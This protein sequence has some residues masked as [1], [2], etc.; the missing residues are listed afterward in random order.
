[1]PVLWPAMV[2]SLIACRYGT[3]L[4][5]T[6]PWTMP[7]LGTEPKAGENAKVSEVRFSSRTLSLPETG[8]GNGV[9]VTGLSGRKIVL[10]PLPA[11]LPANA[12]SAPRLGSGLGAGCSTGVTGDTSWK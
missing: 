4:R 8:T 10:K 11:H 2:T 5:K 12:A 6:S 9:G 1:M 7:R 3:P